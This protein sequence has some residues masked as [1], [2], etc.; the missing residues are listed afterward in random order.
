MYRSSFIVL[1]CFLFSACTPH[2]DE[3]CPLNV[4]KDSFLLR[5]SDPSCKQAQNYKD[6]EIPK[7]YAVSCYSCPDTH[8]FGSETANLHVSYPDFKPAKNFF[9]SD[10][11]AG[12]IA[13]YIDSECSESRNSIKERSDRFSAYVNGNA[14]SKGMNGKE[15]F[16]PI[17]ALDNGVYFQEF[18]NERKDGHSFYFFKN[19]KGEILNL[20]FGDGDTYIT[21]ES[22][23]T[24]D[25]AY[26]TR[27]RVKGVN[28]EEFPVLDKKV[29]EFMEKLASSSLERQQPAEFEY[30]E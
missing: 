8:I 29:A 1:F 25:G 2:C 4:T 19:V 10:L 21:H 6:L 16:A 13:I 28:P 17:K 26:S 23:M 20:Y 12:E 9:S 7:E 30:N 27:Y 15:R 24:A 3:T 22:N 18:I 14:V 5:H 11:S